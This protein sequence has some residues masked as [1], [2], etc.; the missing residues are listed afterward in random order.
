[1]HELTLSSPPNQIAMVRSLKSRNITTQ[2]LVHVHQ[3]ER[4]TLHVAALTVENSFCDMGLCSIQHSP[5][6]S[7]N[8]HQI[9]SHAHAHLLH[10]VQLPNIQALGSFLRS[11]ELLSHSASSQC[12]MHLE[13]SLPWSQEPTT[14]PC[15]EWDKSSLHSQMPFIQDAL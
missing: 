15:P 7:V 1:M 11:Q 14:G 9:A 8:W 6:V 2:L 5:E 13:G 3:T 10:A 12:F 4:N